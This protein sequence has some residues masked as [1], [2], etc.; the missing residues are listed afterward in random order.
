MD[1]FTAFIIIV[2]AAL[3]HASFQLSISV[4]TLLSGRA[5]GAARSHAK[6]LRLSSGFIFGAGVMTLLLIS[7]FA[8]KFI[9][10][11]DESTLQAAW[12]VICGLLLGVGIAVWTVY[13][14]KSKGLSLWIPV[15]VSDYLTERTK[16][17]KRSAEAFGLGMTSVI[18]ELLFIIAPLSVGALVI[19]QLPVV[20]QIV[21]VMAYTIVSILP[22][23]VVMA[24]LGGGHKL[25]KIQKWRDKN[26]RFLQFAAGGGLIILAGFVYVYEVLALLPRLT[27]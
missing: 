7:A 22:L 27:T 11:L 12:V 13:Y 26:K 15:S 6:L 2:F 24:M 5:I 14:R 10:I 3:I 21:G 1:I 23:L 9:N 16:A 20:W 18:S 4:L 25:S 8:L 19:I 17:T